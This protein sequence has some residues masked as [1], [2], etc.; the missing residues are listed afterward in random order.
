MKQY[1]RL[2]L[3]WNTMTTYFSSSHLAIDEGWNSAKGG[4]NVPIYSASDGVVFD[5]FYNDETG[6]AVWVKYQDD[7]NT[8]LFRYIHM[9]KKSTLKVG[10]TIKRGDL[11]GNM[12]TTGNSTGNH[13]HFDVW[14]CPK[15]YSFNWNDR[16]KYAV[17]P[18]DY[19]FLFDDQEM[20]E[21]NK[22]IV[23]V[24]GTSKQVKRDTNKNQIEIVGPLL[25]VRKGAGTNQT[26]LGYIDYGIYDY[27]ETKEANG[28]TWYNVGFGWVAY[29][30]D[31][32]KVYSKEEIKNKEIEDLEKQVEEL[33]IQLNEQKQVIE[34]QKKEIDRLVME[35][36]ILFNLKEFIA[37]ET[38]TYYIK[39]EKGERLYKK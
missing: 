29:L 1:F 13:L 26:V 3:K 4:K 7:S 34:Q 22:G 21:S 15:N 12:G 16:K 9:N 11:I 6:Y 28:Y 35:Q 39:L 18:T 38:G 25:R 17:N 27:S 24:V 10:A 20:G 30:K 8:W 5:N 37:N 19:V 33:T 31:D 2:P 14:K 32:V 36:D 23:R